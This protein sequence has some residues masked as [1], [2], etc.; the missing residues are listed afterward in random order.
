MRQTL[1]D[2]GEHATIPAFARVTTWAEAEKAAK[3]VGFPAVLKP[4]SASG[5]KGIW[6][7]DSV[8]RLRESFDDLMRYTTPE[9][10]PVFRGNVNELIFEQRLVGT[11]HSVEGFVHRGNVYIAGVTDKVTTEPWRLEV[12]HTFPSE[13]P[14]HL[15]GKVHELTATVV[16]TLGLDN[17]P[18]H[19]ECMVDAETGTAKLVEVAARPGGDF[20]TSHLVTLATGTSF[21]RNVVRVATG[22]APLPAD[23][24]P[25]TAGVHKVMAEQAG[26]LESVDGFDVA[27]GRP[28]VQ[29]VVQEAKTGAS[30]TVPPVGYNPVVGAVIATGG[31]PDVVRARLHGA[32]GSVHARIRAA[33]GNG[34]P[35]R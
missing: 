34:G 17:C 16:R 15:L 6:L 23:A 31:S 1:A 19:L 32:A 29:H 11:E 25:L 13:L 4:T 18:I 20:I 21:H 24:Q 33:G 30:V 10:D 8:D 28:G 35:A 22:L 2:A 26:V 14:A 5:S 27:A 9:A 7:L 12:G 3:S